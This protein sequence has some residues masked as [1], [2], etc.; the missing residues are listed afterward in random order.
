MR[1]ALIGNPISHSLSPA[2]FKTAYPGSCHTY[3]LLETTS[4]EEAV[5]RFH[6]EGFNGLNVTAPYKEDILRFTD[7][8]DP[9]VEKLC[10]SNLLLINNGIVSA[11]NTDYYGVIESIKGYVSPTD[12]VVV[13][14]C[15]GAGKAA[16]LAARSTG[17]EVTIVNRS[18]YK[19]KEFSTRVG[20]KYNTIDSLEDEIIGCN[21]FINSI[22]TNM[23]ILDNM[24]YTGKIILEANYRS[25][26]LSFAEKKFNAKYISG[27]SWLLYQAVQ[28]FQLF[29]SI[30]PDLESMRF[31]INNI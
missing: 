23:E 3:E 7:K 1:F 31:M 28:S 17:C 4:V 14:G 19:A 26:Q 10:A 15:G 30:E 16:A 6:N 29:T 25:P 9:I 12:K 20:I 5:K 11:F 27:K 24:D 21:M 18:M 13:L 22:S 8:R 2:L